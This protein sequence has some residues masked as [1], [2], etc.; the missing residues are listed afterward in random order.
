MRVA[1]Y[2][3][4]WGTLGGGE[5]VAA[6][7]GS[8]LSADHDVVLLGH[9]GLDIDLM[10]ERL[11]VDLSRIEPRVVPARVPAVEAASADY[12]LFVNASYHSSAQCLANRGW[13]YVHFP[14][15]YPPLDVG[16]KSAVKDRA[17]GW[18]S[19]EGVAFEERSGLYP[20]EVVGGV[21]IR[22]SDGRAE[23]LVQLPP[24]TELPIHV[25]LARFLP[26]GQAVVPVEV[27]VEGEVRAV[28]ELRPRRGR[29]DRRLSRAT[30][31]VSGGSEAIRLTVRSPVH[32]SGDGDDR[33]GLGVPIAGIQLGDGVGPHVL[34]RWSP[35]RDLD[36]RLG[37][38]HTYD[39][40][41]ANSVF[42]RGWV[43]ERWEV[44]SE[45]LY[46][47]VTLQSSGSKRNL[48]LN[49]GRFFPATSGH[50]KKQLELV[51]AFRSLHAGGSTDWELDLVGGCSKGD[52]SY[53]AEVRA[54]AEGLPVRVHID[55]PGS[56][57]R[58]LYSEASIYWHASGLGEQEDVEPD[59]FEHF[60]ITTVEAMS[61]G[62]VPVVI[63]AAGQKEI[64][65]SGVS[66]FTFTDSDEL[67][68]ITQRLISDG[69]LRE[70]LS[71]GARERAD[72][73]SEERF[74][75]RVR[76]LI[77]MDS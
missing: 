58:D 47:P 19:Q 69:P 77:D 11:Q 42:T 31:T 34:R 30:V 33:D 64:V 38:L 7:I 40:V 75:R 9:D 14:H 20:E 21:P 43:R 51:E 24:G 36:P 3:E 44:D 45:V 32:P 41:L 72:Q 60:G 35:Q 62:D 48:I 37:W 56:V 29:L 26:P 39:V 2:N 6:G 18:L 52:E 67:V 65:E 5:K 28:V 63:G 66:G 53:L 4:H 13:Y 1:V 74:G 12:E 57:L 76:A 50:S 10:S 71:R 23:F 49:V 68:A 73:F 8:A 70:R 17:R 16:W 59:R 22:W 61:A 15:P 27:L 55:A 54:A 46:P 25:Y